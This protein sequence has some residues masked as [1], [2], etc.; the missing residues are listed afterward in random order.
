M[1]TALTPESEKIARSV[2]SLSMLQGNLDLLRTAEKRIADYI[3][4][5][6]DEV[7]YLSITELAEKAQTSEATVVRMAQRA[8]YKGYQAMKI[9]L[10]RDMEEPGA[11]NL[12]YGAIEREDD[13]STIK[14]K[15]FTA[16]ILALNKCMESIKDQA[17]EQATNAIANA[18]KVEI[19]GQGGSAAVA[20]DAHHKFLRI[21]IPATAILDSNMQ[22]M[23]AALLKPG[24]VAIGISHSGVLKDTI[25]T[26]QIAKKAGATTV[27]ITGYE[28]SPLTQESDI[29]LVTSANQTGS[30]S[31]IMSSRIAQLSVIDVLYVS[32]AFSQYDAVQDNLQKTREA[33]ASRRF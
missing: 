20:L 18:R 22:V 26:I 13:I 23:S 7:I 32:V 19:Y 8:G 3:L 6:P 21:G 17:L 14:Q 2:V 10:A 5:H 24:D 31:E 16:N 27:C 11:S 12:I 4:A 15:V 33:T 25:E 9:A 30:H 29:S 1:K 28:K